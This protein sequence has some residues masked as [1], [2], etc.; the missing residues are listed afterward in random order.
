M[1]KIKYDIPV[2]FD[3]EKYLELNDDVKRSYPT[4]EG[5]INHY[6]NDGIKQKR[7]YKTKNTPSDF[8]W[9]IYLAINP[10]VYTSCKNKTSVF[11]HYENHGFSE[12]RFYKLTDVNITEEFDWEN[13]CINNPSLKLTSKI[14]AVRHYYIYGKKQKLSYKLDFK[15]NSIPA[16][17]NWI[18]YNKLNKINTVFLNEKDAISHYLRKGKTKNYLCNFPDNAIPDDFDWV[19]YTELNPD[20]KE[21]FNTKELSMYHYYFTGKKEGR[22]YRLHHTPDDFNC[23]QY[24]QLNDAISSEF[25][26]NEYTIKLHY[27]LF[28]YSQKLPYNS[29]FKNV[30]VDFDW[31]IYVQLNPDIKAVCKNELHSRKHYDSFGIYQNRQY[32]IN[33]DTIVHNT[34]YNNYQFL[35]HKYILNITR[36]I[37][38]IPYSIIKSYTIV[39]KVDIFLIAH[40]H[41]YDIEKFDDFYGNYIN[42][43]TNFC[44]K[45]II[46][47]SIGNIQNKSNKFIYLKCLNQGMDI[48]GKF[49]CINYLRSNRIKYSSILFLHSKSDP[50]MRKLY[51]DPIIDNLFNIVE[52]IKYN[53]YSLFV[54]PLIYMGDYATIVYKDQFANIKNVTCKWN[55]GNSLYLN[56]IDRYHNYNPKTFLF[57]EGN[58]FICNN[59]MAEELYGNIK[60]Y[61]LLNTVFTFDAVWFKAFYNS[62]GFSTGNTI[63]DIFDFFK[64]E[65]TNK[66][67]P[68]NIT[69]GAGHDGH[70][71]NMY[72]H[73]FERIVF[74]VAEKLNCKVKI[75]PYKQNAEYI[76]QLECIN[77]DINKLL[78]I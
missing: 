73:S 38:N 34:K 56:D 59:T 29:N 3:W 30:P 70:P 58:C 24:M 13:Y 2:D 71:D 69:W 47:Y 9:E 43:I 6:I 61:N 26:K 14:E 77:N 17:F 76:Q 33:C 57:P 54:P 55:F 45:V 37:N 10:D 41:C 50:Y 22:I 35:F 72:E 18:L 36:E 60:M 23:K 7:I 52:D 66:M 11:M 46:T 31:K 65:N 12:K 62:R 75:L 8:D 25:K 67:F 5:A 74:K 48:G 51:W 78:N 64:N 28:G 16:N 63:H 40:L 1:N 4:K 42:K 19:W 44:S 39:D 20:V 15:A 27:D 49:V 53:R 21:I 68:N 32:S